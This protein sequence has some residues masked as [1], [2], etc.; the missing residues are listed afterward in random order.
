MKRAFTISTLTLTGLV[1]LLFAASAGAQ[2]EGLSCEEQCYEAESACY[3]DC[4]GAGNPDKCETR[5]EAT[6][7]RCLESCE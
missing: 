4:D 3:D 1:A 7:D 6:A 5:C 2:D